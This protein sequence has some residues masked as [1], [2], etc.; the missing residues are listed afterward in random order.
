MNR[1]PKPFSGFKSKLTA[2]NRLTDIDFVNNLKKTKNNYSMLGKNK[3][4]TN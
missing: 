3:K 1:I 2:D 4:S